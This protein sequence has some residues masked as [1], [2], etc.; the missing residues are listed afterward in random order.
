MIALSQIKINSHFKENVPGNFLLVAARNV[1]G[2]FLLVH[3]K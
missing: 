1:P 3:E 2:N